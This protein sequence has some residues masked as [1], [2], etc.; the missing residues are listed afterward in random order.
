MATDKPSARVGPVPFEDVGGELD[1]ALPEQQPERLS[2]L[3]DMVSSL[4]SKME[5]N[6]GVR[7]YCYQGFWLPDNWVVAA[8]DMQRSFMPLA[9]KL[10]LTHSCPHAS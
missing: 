5:V 6:L 1:T 8:V 9:G 3:A 7:I 10:F 2:H 4:P